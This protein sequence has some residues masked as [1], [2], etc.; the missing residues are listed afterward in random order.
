[1]G[2]SECTVYF[3]G[4]EKRLAFSW[5]NAQTIPLAKPVLILAKMWLFA[6]KT[7]F[8]MEKRTKHYHLISQY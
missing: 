7:G 3:A 6:K 5:K 2:G 8:F 1:V 4:N